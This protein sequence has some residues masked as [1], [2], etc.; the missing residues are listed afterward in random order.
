L[1]DHGYVDDLMTQKVVDSDTRLM[2]MLAAQAAHRDGSASEDEEAVAS[3]EKLSDAEKKDT[4]QKALNM[5]ASNGDVERIQRILGAK[6]KEFVDINAPD[7]EGTAPLI[8]ASCFV[9]DSLIEVT[10]AMLKLVPGSRS[11]SY[12]FI[13]CWCRC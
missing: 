8:Y 5:A 2:E 12:S 1:D 7:E 13:R 4:L 10:V 3:N 11:G 6:A 9:S